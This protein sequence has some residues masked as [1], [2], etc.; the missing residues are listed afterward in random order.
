M[1]CEH[2]RFTGRFVLL[3]QEISGERGQERNA[4]NDKGEQK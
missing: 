1:F 4:G 2:H 3:P